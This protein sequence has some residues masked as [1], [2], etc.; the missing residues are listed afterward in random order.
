MTNLYKATVNVHEIQIHV[1]SRTADSSS[2]SYFVNWPSHSKIPFSPDFQKDNHFLFFLLCSLRPN[3]C[4]FLKIKKRGKI[5][6]WWKPM[7]SFLRP[8]FTVIS[9][10]LFFWTSFCSLPIL[11]ND[12]TRN[13]VGQVER[14]LHPHEKI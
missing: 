7:S 13:A 12:Q 9:L 4:R 3:S 6:C 11:A 10:N 5:S 2:S 8:L 1:E 14:F